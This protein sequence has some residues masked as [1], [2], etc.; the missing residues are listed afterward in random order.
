MSASLDVGKMIEGNLTLR[1]AELNAKMI[2]G[3]CVDI[4]CS[5]TVNIGAVY[6]KQFHVKSRGG[7]TVGGLHGSMEVGQ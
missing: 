4:D 7:A 5:E 3:D 2:N 6:S 1:C